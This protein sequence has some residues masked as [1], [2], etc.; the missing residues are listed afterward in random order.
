MSRMVRLGINMYIFK[1]GFRNKLVI[2]LGKSI[3]AEKKLCFVVYPYSVIKCLA[4]KRISLKKDRY[5]YKFALCAIFK[6]EALYLK[7]WIEYHK[8]IGIERIYL[9]NNNSTDNYYEVLKPYIDEGLVVLRNMPGKERQMD[10]YNDCLMRYK[11]ESK[12]IGVIDIDEFIFDKEN[13]S[14]NKIEEVFNKDSSIGGVQ[15]NWTIFGSSHLE[16]YENEPVTKRF[17]YSSNK[18]FDM[19]RHT[20]SFV[21]PRKTLC[22]LNPHYAMYIDG[23]YPVNL[24]GT[25][26]EGAMNDDINDEVRINHYFCKSKEEF[27]LKIK[28]GTADGNPIR[29]M[30]LFDYHDKND[31]YDDSM[32]IFY[33]EY[34]RMKD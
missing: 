6:D 28:R 5:S 24:N 1:S 10:A 25:K 22:F 7:E 23:F 19:N 18:D 17:I 21:N 30:G 16:K 3:N 4:L 34:E 11:Y 9:Y 2:K 14:L 15:I 33:D 12:Y 32:K 27:M 26:V 13:N 29:T 20:K 31:V 8:F